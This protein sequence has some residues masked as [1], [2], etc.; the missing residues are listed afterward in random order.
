MI[1]DSLWSE[2]RKCG[3]TDDAPAINL[4]ADD[5]QANLSASHSGDAAHLAADDSP[6]NLSGRA[7]ALQPS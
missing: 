3:A 4:A 2:K 5:S 7:L 6:A 1:R